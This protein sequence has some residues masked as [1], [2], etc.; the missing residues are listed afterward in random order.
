MDGIHPL[1]Y[2]LTIVR[3]ESR[4][5]KM[6]IYAASACLPYCA[7]KLIQTDVR[8]STELDGL[9]VQDKYKLLAGLR[10]NILEHDP[11]TKLPQL[12]NGQP[13]ADVAEGMFTESGE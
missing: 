3:D 4:E 7:Q 10:A 12:V 13:V 8:V 6:R 11:D 2:L 5:E 9:S 1:T